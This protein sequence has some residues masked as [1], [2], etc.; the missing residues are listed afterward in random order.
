MGVEPT[1]QGETL[2]PFRIMALPTIHF[3]DAKIHLFLKMSTTFSKN[4]DFYALSG[5]YSCSFAWP[6]EPKVKSRIIGPNP[7]AELRLWYSWQRVEIPSESTC[8]E[9]QRLSPSLWPP[10]PRDS[11]RAH[12]PQSDVGAKPRRDYFSKSFVFSK[13]SII[14]AVLKRIKETDRVKVFKDI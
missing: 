10:L 13:N 8:L 11:C 7:A 1:P 2:P 3:P 4:F 14:F 6:K 12:P 5:W 9:Y